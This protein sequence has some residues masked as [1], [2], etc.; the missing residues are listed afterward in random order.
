MPVIARFFLAADAALFQKLLEKEGIPSTIPD[1]D[2]NTITVPEE[3]AAR[4]EAIY[5]AHAKA[6][7]ALADTPEPTPNKDY[8]FCAVWILT[9]IAFMLL[10][11]AL[12]IPSMR[13]DA[14]FNAWLFFLG[15]MLLTGILGGLFIAIGIA[16]WRMIPTALKRKTGETNQ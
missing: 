2:S 16:F 12:F 15:T 11:A 10:Y 13:N 3:H 8:P 9:A 4:A 7:P 5:A 1:H 14:D 6:N